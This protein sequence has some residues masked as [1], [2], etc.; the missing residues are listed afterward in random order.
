MEVGYDDAD[1][2]RVMVIT[3]VDADRRRVIQFLH[4]GGYRLS[5]IES[6]RKLAS[7][8]A[9]AAGAIAFSVE[10][11]LAPEHRHPAQ[12][13]DSLTVY[14]WLLGRGYHGHEI[15]LV[16][17]SAGGGLA[18]GTVLAL[19]D[20]SMPLPAGVVAV[21]PWTDMTISGGSIVTRAATDL[22]PTAVFLPVLREAFV[23]EDQWDDPRAS[24]LCGDLAGLP[25]LFLQAGDDESL[26]DDAIRFGAKASQ[27]GVDVTFDIVPEMQHVFIRAV[28]SA[29]EADEGVARVGAFLRRSFV[30]AADAARIAADG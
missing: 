8:I 3:P 29:P 27:A 19:K 22:T 20:A 14:R 26:R 17:D 5:S 7:H 18:L 10:Y 23:S 9:K 25:P 13:E 24:P 30:R 1:G 12:V 4:G 15:A 21:S 11:R 28:G 2:V 6:H 16:G